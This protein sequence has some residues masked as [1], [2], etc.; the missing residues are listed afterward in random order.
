MSKRRTLAACRGIRPNNIAS[1][2]HSIGG[3]LAVSVAAELRDAGF[4]LPGAILSVSPWYD[5][6]LKN[7]TIDRN[8]AD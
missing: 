3:N 2:G 7:E 1:I 4:A 5:L 6:E 8:G